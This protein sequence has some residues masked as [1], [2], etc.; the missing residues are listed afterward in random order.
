MRVNKSVEMLE[1]IIVP[2]IMH[3]EY[4]FRCM[5]SAYSNAGF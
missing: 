3:R 2:S 5:T 4:Q 1:N